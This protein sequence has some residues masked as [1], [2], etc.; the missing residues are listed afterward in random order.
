MVVVRSG[1]TAYGYPGF[2]LSDPQSSIAVI[3]VYPNPDWKEDGPAKWV[4]L[5]EGVERLTYVPPVRPKYPAM[6]AADDGNCL[7]LGDWWSSRSGAGG[8]SLVI[9]GDGAELGRFENEALAWPVRVDAESYLVVRAIGTPHLGPD[10]HVSAFTSDRFEPLDDLQTQFSRVEYVR[11]EDSGILVVGTEED[12][13]IVVA[14]SYSYTDSALTEKSEVSFYPPTTAL[15]FKQTILVELYSEF[16]PTS[17]LV[18]RY[19]TTNESVVT[20]YDRA[21]GKEMWTT[22][23]ETDWNGHSTVVAATLVA[24][25]IHTILAETLGDRGEILV[26]DSE[27]GQIVRTVPVGQRPV[28]TL[29]SQLI[30]MQNKYLLVGAYRPSIEITP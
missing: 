21:T 18:A 9:N 26:L 15:K 10:V 2:L 17:V 12:P 29:N 24:N 11:P 1:A 19:S 22:V 5:Q 3:A 25:R 27:D 23:L 16:A 20:L 28:R 30:V 13:A 6:T 8:S 4:V 7:I 14:K